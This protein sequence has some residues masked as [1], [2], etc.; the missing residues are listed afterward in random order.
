M[1]A[2][3]LDLIMHNDTTVCLCIYIGLTVVPKANQKY[4]GSTGT[5]MSN[6]VL[7]IYMLYAFKFQLQHGI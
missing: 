7:H 5:V 3:T 4:S 1:Y 2:H 6:C